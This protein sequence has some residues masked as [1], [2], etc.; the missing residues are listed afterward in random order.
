MGGDEGLGQK[1]RNEPYRI[2]LVDV[3][4]NS[5]SRE[6]ADPP[7]ASTLALRQVVGPFVR[8][9]R[10]A[11]ES[12]EG[13][14]DD[15]T[16]TLVPKRG[17]SWPQWRS[18]LEPRVFCGYAAPTPELQGGYHEASGLRRFGEEGDRRESLKAL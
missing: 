1:V 15:G 17:L 5:G 13:K 18:R 6:S 10:A 14:A 12:R 4:G 7:W 2:R 16:T 9:L 11:P 3:G 8:L